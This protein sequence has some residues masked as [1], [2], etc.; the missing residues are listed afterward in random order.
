[1]IIWDATQCNAN[2]YASAFEDMCYLVDK[3]APWPPEEVYK[4]EGLEG[5]IKAVEDAK[6]H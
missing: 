5:F 4:D 2:T 1:M 3:Y 6:S